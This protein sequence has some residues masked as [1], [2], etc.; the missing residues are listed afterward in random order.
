MY[1]LI[2][3]NDNTFTHSVESRTLFLE[4]QSNM[5]KGR[6]VKEINEE[7][8]NKEMSVGEGNGNTRGE[9]HRGKNPTT[10]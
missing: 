4:Y 3:V 9:G 2:Q 10:V 7:V 8:K 5:I 6:H 1:I